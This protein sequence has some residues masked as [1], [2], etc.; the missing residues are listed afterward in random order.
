MNRTPNPESDR[1]TVVTEGGFPL[2]LVHFLVSVIGD[3][4]TPRPSDSD[5]E[6]SLGFIQ[7]NAAVE[8]WDGH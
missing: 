8:S 2:G 4:G 5:G 7:A 1:K 3:K 6:I